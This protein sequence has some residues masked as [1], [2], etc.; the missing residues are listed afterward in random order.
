MVGRC[1]LLLLTA[2]ARASDHRIQQLHLE[3]SSLLADIRELEHTVIE[4]LIA[5]AIDTHGRRLAGYSATR[6]AINL[7][8]DFVAASR[9]RDAALPP[10]PGRARGEG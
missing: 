3:M 9:R 1:S 4:Q 5:P 10:P 2:M 6:G 8:P 7:V